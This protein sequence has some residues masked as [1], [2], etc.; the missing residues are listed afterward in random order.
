MLKKIFPFLFIISIAVSCSGPANSYPETSV[1]VA[2]AFIR[3]TLKN[4]I[5]EAKK[6][7][8]PDDENQQLLND[9]SRWYSRQN[10]TK[11]DAFKAAEVLIYET[12]TVVPDS[13]DIIYYSNTS[14]Q[15]IKNKLKLVRSNNKWQ[16][17]FKYTVS[18]NL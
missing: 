12:E 8:I 1:E 18:G 7:I 2:T 3:S 9:Y 14:E 6:Y 4:D 5:N 15:N 13:V 17:D 11:A 16:V 10:K